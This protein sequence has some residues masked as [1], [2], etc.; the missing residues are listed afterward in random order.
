MKYL[1]QALVAFG[2]LAVLAC[3]G[4]AQMDAPAARQVDAGLK[5]ALHGLLSDRSQLG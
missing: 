5:R 1:R 2:L 3:A 4:V